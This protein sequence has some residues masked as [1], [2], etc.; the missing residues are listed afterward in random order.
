MPL[1]LCRLSRPSGGAGGTAEQSSGEELKAR[2][3]RGGARRREERGRSMVRGS[4]RQREGCMRVWF[5]KL[6]QAG[7]KRALER[8]WGWRSLGG[9]GERTVL[10]M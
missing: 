6:G 3:E 4:R 7:R 9:T 1:G 10:G 5:A 2:A 8:A